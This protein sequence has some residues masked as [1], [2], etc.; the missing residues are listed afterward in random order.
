MNWDICLFRYSHHV[1]VHV[2]LL[3]F[4]NKSCKVATDAGACGLGS[5]KS[6]DC[7]TYCVILQEVKPV[8]KRCFNTEQ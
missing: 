2:P 7:V 4:S 5:I 8:A 6:M 1:T 3:S